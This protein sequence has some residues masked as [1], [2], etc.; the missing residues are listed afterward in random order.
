MPLACLPE[1]NSQEQIEA[2][3]GR[4]YCDL[5][6]ALQENGVAQTSLGLFANCTFSLPA[7]VRIHIFVWLSVQGIEEVQQV[8][9]GSCQG[10][11]LDSAASAES[12]SQIADGQR[13]CLWDSNLCHLIK[14]NQVR[15]YARESKRSSTWGRLGT[16]ERQ[17]SAG[18]HGPTRSR[19]EPDSTEEFLEP[20]AFFHQKTELSRHSSMSMSCCCRH[21]GNQNQDFPFVTRQKH[22]R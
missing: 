9:R 3:V 2:S 15:Y 10:E 19:V 11:C 18:T 21:F 8:S 14:K 17:R 4:R 7:G 20:N 16:R 1:L 13:W 12:S 6:S 22:G 5:L